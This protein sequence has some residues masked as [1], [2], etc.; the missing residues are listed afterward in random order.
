MAADS[1]PVAGTTRN[2]VRLSAWL[3]VVAVAAV[4]AC[5]LLINP[6]DRGER[7]RP[8]PEGSWLL[9][10]VRAQALG[11]AFPARRGVEIKEV[12][13]HV[14][15]CVL[16]MIAAGAGLHQRRRLSGAI[17]SRR[18]WLTEPAVWFAVAI[19]VSALAAALSHAPRG[20]AGGTVMRFFWFAWWW[21]LAACLRPR[22]TRRVVIGLIAAAALTSIVGLWHRS[23]RA[24][25]APL[26][27]PLGNSLFLAACLLPALLIAGTFALAYLRPGLIAA[28]SNQRDARRVDEPTRRGHIFGLAC[29]LATGVILWAC[30]QTGSRS[31][32]LGL[33]VGL[34]VI[35]YLM[36]DRN[37][38]AW[39]LVV[40]ALTVGIA[41]G[42]F[43]LTGGDFVDTA[44][45]VVDELT[46]RSA[47]IRARVEHEWPY[48]TS[49][50]LK[51]PWL[52][53][54]EGGFGRLVGPYF[55]AK[56]LFDPMVL[57]ADGVSWES[58]AHN[59]VLELLTS[60]GVFGAAAMLAAV[61]LTLRAAFRTC[62]RITQ[63]LRRVWII[64]LTGAFAG[65]CVEE[66]TDVAL[67]AP[68]FAPVWLTVWACL[69]ALL[70][71]QRASDPGNAAGTQPE[72]SAAR[73]D[74]AE[75]GAYQSDAF[76]RWMVN[77]ACCGR[78]IFVTVA[79]GLACFN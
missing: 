55:R 14:A 30:I 12:V 51:R 58:H 65:A 73:T 40:M 46:G 74:K 57:T 7:L 77:A 15:A 75:L 1:P 3:A 31:A 22:H 2:S 54:G 79:L 72:A 62:E 41:A 42:T 23:V 50:F 38:R 16:A 61:F 53:D 78:L 52:G 9:T 47:S 13:F 29:L 67:H 49:M 39:I 10:V 20:A 25:E 71:A 33:G 63:P 27:Y 70:R 36:A 48:A 60:L 56:Q 45:S 4:F 28:I 34:L 32:K 68:G 69:W 21:P 17:R 59:E 35:V 19:A 8:W 64:A 44:V 18:A 5:L 76:P 24:P 6:D 11:Y 26:S 66:L 43:F 37:I